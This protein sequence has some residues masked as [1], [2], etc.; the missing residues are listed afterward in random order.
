MGIMDKIKGLLKGR[1]T[2]VKKGIDTVS[3]QAEK[4]VGTKHAA[5]VDAVS[6]KAKD[7][8]DNLT[9]DQASPTTPATPATPAA[10]AAS[11]PPATPATPPETPP[12][13]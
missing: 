4:A 8:V 1:E 2:Q 6:D 9:K 10:P 11:T 7:A 13:I 5:K 3:D 12:A